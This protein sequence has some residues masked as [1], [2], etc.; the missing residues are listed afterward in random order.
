MFSASTFTVVGP[1][2]LNQYA[3][4]LKARGFREVMLTDPATRGWHPDRYPGESRHMYRGMWGHDYRAPFGAAGFRTEEHGIE[5][6]KG[7]KKM[8]N[9][10]FQIYVGMT[11]D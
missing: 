11:K 2:E 5:I 4:V 8:S 1:A 3:E 9:A 10:P 6:F 7:H